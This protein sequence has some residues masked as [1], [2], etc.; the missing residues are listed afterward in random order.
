MENPLLLEQYEAQLF[1]IIR[2]HL[3]LDQHDPAIILKNFKLIYYFLTAPI[4]KDPTTIGKILGMLTDNIVNPNGHSS[5]FNACDMMHFE[6]IVSELH[7]KKLILISKLVMKSVSKDNKGFKYI[8][9][10]PKKLSVKKLLLTNQ[11]DALPSKFTKED[12]DRILDHITFDMAK[13]L[14]SHAMMALQDCML[15]TSLPK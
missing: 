5:L 14:L 1:S 13:S 9:T 7:F 6:K 3:S 4:C 2:Q 8:E 11:E 12:K 15:L 10:N